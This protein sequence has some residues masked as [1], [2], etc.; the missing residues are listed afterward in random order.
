M[1]L[2]LRR[3]VHVIS[4]SMEF[5]ETDDGSH[6]WYFLWVR[7][8]AGL[9]RASEKAKLD[10]WPLFRNAAKHSH[11]ANR[12]LIGHVADAAGVEQN[13]VS[14]VFGHHPLIAPRDERMRDVLG[15][16]LVHLA[17]VSFDEKRGHAG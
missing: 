8:A 12:F 9:S 16:A 1:P 7:G 6:V 17:T 11:F 15:I 13:N 3:L 10:F 14:F 5:L 4:N 2:F